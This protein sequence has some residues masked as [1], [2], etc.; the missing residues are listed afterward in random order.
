MTD[1]H[2]IQSLKR[3]E[4]SLPRVEK[5]LLKE[6]L[7]NQASKALASVMDITAAA[8]NVTTNTTLGGIDEIDPLLEL[9]I[10][11]TLPNWD[12][13]T[14]ADGAEWI[15]AI[16]TAKGRYFEH[17]VVD[18]LNEGSMVGGVVLPKGYT[19]ELAPTMNNPGWDV[20]I[21][22]EGG[23]EAEFLQLKATDSM[24]YLHGALE[25]YPEMTFVATSEVSGAADVFDSG[26]T[27]EWLENQTVGAIDGADA[28]DEVGGLIGGFG[29][30]ALI[31][32]RTGWGVKMGD[33]KPEEARTY[34]VDAGSRS[35]TAQASGFA[36]A[37]IVGGW[38]AVPAVVASYW[39]I[40]TQQ[41]DQRVM[42]RFAE[43]TDRLRKLRVFQQERILAKEQ[44]HGLF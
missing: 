22:D 12:S 1:S 36:A 23:F 5:G 11:E 41:K 31:A 39:W 24:A 43:A 18:R 34:I 25:Q 33:M 20:R 10:S 38:V 9:A 3:L 37:W 4:C 32:A 40:G 35:L 14:A 26:V 13:S 15:G 17:L 16:N 28:M 21:L 29:A 2:T 27:N 8:A 19:A 30:L 6:W 42:Q 7:E 44:Y